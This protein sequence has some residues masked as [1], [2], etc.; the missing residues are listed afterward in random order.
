MKRLVIFI[1]FDKKMFAKK[2]KNEKE[3]SYKKYS[4]C[5]SLLPIKKRKKRNAL[6]ANVLNFIYT[7]IFIFSFQIYFLHYIFFYLKNKKI[8]KLERNSNC[9]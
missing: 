3:I 9:L 2:E 4:N 7:S 8:K 6:F 1:V 5:V